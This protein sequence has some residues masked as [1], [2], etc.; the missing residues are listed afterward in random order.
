MEGDV[1]FGIPTLFGGLAYVGPNDLQT[2]LEKSEDFFKR[3]NNYKFDLFVQDVE[4]ATKVLLT[5]DSQITS[6]KLFSDSFTFI[7]VVCSNTI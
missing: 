4:I 7:D 5:T 3:E 2:A 1:P 6:V